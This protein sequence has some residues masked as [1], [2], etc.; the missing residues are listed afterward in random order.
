MRRFVT[1]TQDDQNYDSFLDIVANLVGILVILIMVVGVR[2]RQVVSATALDGSTV[3]TVTAPAVEVAVVNPPPTEPLIFEIEEPSGPSAEAVA[4]QLR[5]EK[6]SAHELQLGIHQIAGRIED[7]TRMAAIKAEERNQM[8]LAI[9]MAEKALAKRRQS[10]NTD[11]QVELNIANALEKSRVELATLHT[12]INS[13][14][15][16]VGEVEVIQNRPTPMAKLV[17]GNEEHFR[18]QAGRIVHVPI[19]EM[20]SELTRDARNNRWKL[21]NTDTITELLGPRNGFTMKYTFGIAT[22]KLD[23]PD[24]PRVVSLLELKRFAMVPQATNLGER[25]DDAL[26]SGSDLEK[27]LAQLRS[28]E[29]TITLWAYPDSYGDFRRVKEYLYEKGFVTAAMPVTKGYP[30]AGSPAGTTSAAQ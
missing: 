27:K 6:S 26:T 20:V 5:Q 17:F 14:E 15:S 4:H 12:Q 25:V 22:R 1:E 11:Q 16:V 29:T 18:L 30:I 8:Q 7:V 21:D 3:E 2:A 19:T 10:L 24:G 13:V 23:T 28:D 9:S